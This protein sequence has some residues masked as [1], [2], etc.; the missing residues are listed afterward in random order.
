MV[1]FGKAFSSNPDLV[2]RRRLNAPLAGFNADTLYGGSSAGYT[3]YPV[4]DAV[5]VVMAGERFSC[6]N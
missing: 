5:D 2:N 1:A 3:D 4:L 6:L